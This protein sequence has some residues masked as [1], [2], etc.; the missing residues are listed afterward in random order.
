MKLASAAVIA[1]AAFLF[2]VPASTAWACGSDSDCKVGH[3]SSGKC[4]HCGSDSDCKGHSHCSGGM[5][6]SCGSDSD[7]KGGRCSSGRCSNAP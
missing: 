6:N 4:G 1:V 7:C 5:C 3:C 2:L